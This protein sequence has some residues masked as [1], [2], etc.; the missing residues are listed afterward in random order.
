MESS[1]VQNETLNEIRH[2]LKLVL[3]REKVTGLE[4]IQSRLLTQ[5]KY[6]NKKDYYYRLLPKSTYCNID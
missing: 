3:M 6:C 5:T 2:R 1:K 4:Y